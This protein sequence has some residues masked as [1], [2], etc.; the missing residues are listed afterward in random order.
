[1]AA[2]SRA[3]GA[4]AEQVRAKV[5]VGRSRGR[6]AL[7]LRQPVRRRPRQSRASDYGRV[8]LGIVVLIG[9][10]AL[11]SATRVSEQES[12]VFRA[13]NNLPDGARAPVWVV[14][15]LGSLAAIPATA[16]V[17]FFARLRRLAFELLLA[18]GT[19][20]VLAKVVKALVERG[21]PR[22]LLEGVM[23]RGVHEGSEGFVSGHAAVAVAL[24]A[25]AS[26]WLKP[27]ARVA[28]GVLA[29]IVCVARV[30]V[31]AHLPLDVIGG[32]GLGYAIGALVNSIFGASAA[33][34]RSAE[35]RRVRRGLCTRDPGG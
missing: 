21:R 30:Y 34:A 31:G 33:I 12:N 25:T 29:T 11:A 3:V 9:T 13:I 22:A 26:P 2:R 18:G 14:M 27:P 15:Q 1:M 5:G 8:V 23:L 6:S 32:A 24:A 7:G 35:P 10:T 4:K 20:Y 16:A 17:A 19:A 28:L